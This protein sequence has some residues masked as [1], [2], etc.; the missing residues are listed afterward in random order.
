MHPAESGPSPKKRSPSPCSR[1]LM[2]QCHSLVPKEGRID[3]TDKREEGEGIRFTGGGLQR[4]RNLGACARR[5]RNVGFWNHL[6]G[7]TARRH[8]SPSPRKAWK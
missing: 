8:G 6:E 4:A 7:A 2:S 3:G 5:A 1:D